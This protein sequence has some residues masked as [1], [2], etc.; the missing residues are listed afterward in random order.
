MGRVKTHSMD[1]EDRQQGDYEHADPTAA[2]RASPEDTRSTLA[3]IGAGSNLGMPESRCAEAPAYLKRHLAGSRALR[4]RIHWHRML[5]VQPQ[6][7]GGPFPPRGLRAF[8]RR[9]AKAVSECMEQSQRFVVIGGDHSTA[10]GTWNGA[11]KGLHRRG[12]MDPRGHVPMG[13]LWIDAHMDAHTTTTTPSGRVHGMPVATLLGEG[14]PALEFFGQGQPACVRPEHLCMV[15]VR[16]YEPEEAAL[17]RR[18]GVQ[19][20]FIEEVQRRGLAAVMREALEHVAARTAGFGIAL[21]LD[22][23]DPEEAPAVTTPVSLGLSPGALLPA[24]RQAC[25]D[26]RFIGMEIVEFNPPAEREQRTAQLVEQLVVA[27][28]P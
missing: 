6:P 1:T 17:L 11:C 13:L 5:S 19:I 16:S 25:R 3:L 22:S 26:P 10:I 24:L 18:L 4:G 21:D 14:D 2:G 8:T 28:L 7:P 20:Y 12:P 23:I 27:A 9:L 15:G